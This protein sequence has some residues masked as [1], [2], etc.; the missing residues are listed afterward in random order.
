MLAEQNLQWEVMNRWRFTLRSK[1]SCVSMVLFRTQHWDWRLLLPQLPFHFLACPVLWPALLQEFP[2]CHL[3]PS[4]ARAHWSSET[5]R[6]TLSCIKTGEGQ[7]CYPLVNNSVKAAQGLEQQN[8]SCTSKMKIDQY[9]S[10]IRWCQNSHL[11]PIYG[12]AFEEV[13]HFVSHFR[14]R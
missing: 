4:P 6:A 13:L 7:T 1:L 5:G 11:V 3:C 8:T 9:L 10:M 12:I 2:I 14:G